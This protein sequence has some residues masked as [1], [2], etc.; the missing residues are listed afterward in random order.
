[1]AQ[2]EA[3]VELY[4]DG[5]GGL[6]IFREGDESGFYMAGEVPGTLFERDA[7][8]IAAGHT[9]TW[10][11]DLPGITRDQVRRLNAVHVATW[12]DG[13]ATIHNHPRSKARIYLGSG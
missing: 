13:E 7:E 12:E 11:M 10:R 3:A 6:Y 5:A 2:G 1:M 9:S 4:E 8:R